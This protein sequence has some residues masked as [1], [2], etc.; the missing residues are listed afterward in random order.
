MSFI[1][2]DST[3]PTF[4][5]KQS[6]THKNGSCFRC[7]SSH[8]SKIN[9]HRWFRLAFFYCHLFRK[10]LTCNFQQARSRICLLH[11]RKTAG[12]IKRWKAIEP[13]VLLRPGWLI[14]E[15]RRQGCSSRNLSL[16]RTEQVDC[17]ADFTSSAHSAT[18]SL[19]KRICFHVVDKH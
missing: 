18:S 14:G 16:T 1:H 8:R 2:D 4:Q 13:M 10:F 5:L 9:V 15:F 12:W 6:L 17:E 11:C 7:G 3:L 19:P